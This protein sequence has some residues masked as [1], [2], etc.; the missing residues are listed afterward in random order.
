VL[1]IYRLK[2]PITAITVIRP[3]DHR[4]IAADDTEED[5]IE[6]GILFF[7]ACSSNSIIDDNS[8]RLELCKYHY[9]NL[10]SCYWLIKE[11]LFRIVA[12][13][14]LGS[15]ELLTCEGGSGKEYHNC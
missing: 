4:V 2:E 10:L 14:R 3:I 15:L 8:I 13:Y 9:F 5:I 11:L 1:C 6:E 7:M 12:M